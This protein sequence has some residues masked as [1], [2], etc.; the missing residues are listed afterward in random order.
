MAGHGVDYNCK[1]RP[2]EEKREVEEEEEEEV[3]DAP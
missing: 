1:F 2:S 3:D